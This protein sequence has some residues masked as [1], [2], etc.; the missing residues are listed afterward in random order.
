M[1]AGVTPFL[2][3]FAGSEGTT[4]VFDAL[5]RIDSV[6]IP[7]LEPLDLH[8][9]YIGEVPVPQR[10]HW[11][12][13]LLSFPSNPNE[14]AAWWKMLRATIPAMPLPDSPPALES[15]LTVG[16]KLRCSALGIDVEAAPRNSLVDRLLGRRSALER[17]AEVL[18]GASAV[19]LIFERRNTVKRAISSYRM[20]QERKS[21][22]TRRNDGPTVMDPKLL[23][24]ELGRYEA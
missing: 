8:Q 2:A 23:L 21:Q 20:T 16:I 19:L 10:W 11:I 17:L 9:A 12:R 13:G 15:A 14:R 18:A 24:T 6:L 5:Q 1:N 3:L 7:A 4:F 22:F